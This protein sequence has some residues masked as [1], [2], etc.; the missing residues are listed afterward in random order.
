MNIAK[1]IFISFMAN[2]FPIQTLGPDANENTF[3]NNF[4]FSMNRSGLK[5]SGLSQYFLLL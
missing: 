2:F 1:K 3:A 5:T 4:G